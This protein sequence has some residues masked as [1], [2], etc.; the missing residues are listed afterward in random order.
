MSVLVL[1]ATYEPLQVIPITRAI[2][3]VLAK[4]VEVI[5]ATDQVYRSTSEEVPVP[6]VVRLLYF[7]RVPYRA[8]LPFSR[9]ALVKRDGGLCQYCGKKG[10]TI[11]HVQPRS[12]GGS[13]AWTN[14][15]LACRRC[16]GKKDNKTL[17]ELGWK[18]LREPKA[19]KG[20]QW[21]VVGVARIDPSWAPYLGAVEVAA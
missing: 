7:V 19:P 15:V 2:G 5:E 11:D 4:K 12:R 17:A 13:N 6:A 21:R 14:V 3:L 9:S 18:L 8:T 10:D 1:N 20:V 16:N